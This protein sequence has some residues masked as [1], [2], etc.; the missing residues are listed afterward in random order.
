MGVIELRHSTQANDRTH[1]PRGAGRN[2][3]AHRQHPR[4]PNGKVQLVVTARPTDT[5]LEPR[6]T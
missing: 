5:P 3:P 1:G 4:T 2:N 6:T